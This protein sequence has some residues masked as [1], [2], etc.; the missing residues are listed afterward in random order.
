MDIAIVGGGPAGA[1][2]GYCLAKEGI[3]ATIF[4]DSHPREKP[5]GG[6]ISEL[7]LRKFPFIKKID[8]V[9]GIGRKIRIIS[10]VGT[11]AVIGK[12]FIMGISR[13]LLDKYILEMAKNEGAQLIEERVLDIKEKNN[14]WIIKTNKGN[15]YAKLIVGAD[16]TNSIVRKNILGPH[17]K[18]NLTMTYGYIVKGIE[19]ELTLM[20]F[21]WGKNGYI[22]VFPRGNHTSI[23]IGT[24]LTKSFGIKKHLDFFIK[25]YYPR[26][27]KLH[28]FAAMIPTI[29]N[30]EFFRLPTAGKNWL[31]IGDAAGHVDPISA[32]GITYAL[33][34]AKLAA[35]A[36]IYCEPEKFDELWRK[37]YGNEFIEAIKLKNILYN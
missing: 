9:K 31:V 32:E 3:K 17:S 25:N 13:L 14:S 21:L 16:G 33:W 37:E 8:G 15:K 12:G 36:I 22:W 23:G 11:E 20:K 24:E 27:K 2:L 4:D 30:P 19:N 29:T 7:A 18:E 6:G 26:V 1:Y 35:K 10:P 5:C 34:S 28:H